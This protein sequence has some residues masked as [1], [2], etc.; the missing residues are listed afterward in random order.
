MSWEWIGWRGLP[1]AGRPLP[2]EPVDAP[3]PHAPPLPRPISLSVEFEGSEP[4]AE[5]RRLTRAFLAD[6]QSVHGLPVSH[7]ARD[8]IELVVSELVTNTRKYAPGPSLLILEVRNGCVNV[9]V[10]DSNPA[11][12]AIL[13]PDP[14]RVGQHGLE[15]I[16]AAALTF[17]I[18]REPVG[19]RITASI[20]L[21]H[22][23]N[24]DAADRER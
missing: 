18:H 13:P 12:P 7:R 4:I 9:A 23:P 15:I 6:V 21:A 10:W 2:D 11:L 24:T 3:A 1:A 17:Q 14:A 19:K 22:E 20:E 8:M 16:M 5:A